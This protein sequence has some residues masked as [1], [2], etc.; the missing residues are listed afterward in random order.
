MHWC[1]ISFKSVYP[2]CTYIHAYIVKKMVEEKVVEKEN[3]WKCCQE[4]T[5]LSCMIFIS[6]SKETCFTD[7]FFEKETL[8]TFDLW[9]WWV[10][11]HGKKNAHSNFTGIL[12]GI[13]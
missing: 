11:S 9:W 12:N 5:F 2:A 3:I 10:K 6:G 4:V 1:A 7:N 8:V 13:L